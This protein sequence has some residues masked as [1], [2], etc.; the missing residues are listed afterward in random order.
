[1]MNSGVNVFEVSPSYKFMFTAIVSLLAISYYYFC[2]K[3][4][5]TI[6]RNLQHAE[7]I[8]HIVALEVFA[9]AGIYMVQSISQSISIGGTHFFVSGIFSREKWRLD[10]VKGYFQGSESS[11][12]PT[13]YYLV[14]NDFKCIFSVASWPRKFEDHEELIAW[15]E[16][17]ELINDGSSPLSFLRMRMSKISVVSTLFWCSLLLQIPLLG[18]ML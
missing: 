13:Y 11:L 18:I 1:M 12:D 2:I 4:G 5:V 6:L 3:G 9:W 7:K 8:E 15:I 14:D 16:T 10:R 17:F